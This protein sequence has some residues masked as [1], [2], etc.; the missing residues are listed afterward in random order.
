MF[1]HQR[2]G[3]FLILRLTFF[4]CLP[5]VINLLNFDNSIFCF[6]AH[7]LKGRRAR[8]AILMNLCEPMNLFDIL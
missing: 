8:A 1:S 6:F 4:I 3:N 5:L 7:I 2:T